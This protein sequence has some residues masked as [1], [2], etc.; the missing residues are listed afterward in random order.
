M[1]LSC[2]KN[3]ELKLITNELLSIYPP[4]CM[5]GEVY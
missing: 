5:G 4:K 3:A 2:P 1:F